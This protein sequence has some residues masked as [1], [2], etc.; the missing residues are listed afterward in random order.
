MKV[1]YI[2]ETIGGG[3]RRHL[4]LLLENLNDKYELVVIHGP[5]FDN[6]FKENI[7]KYKQKGIKLYCLP[8]FQREIN[9]KQDIR[10][11]KSVLNILKKEKPDIVHCHSSK[12]GVIGR[13]AAKVQHVP[14]I[15]YTPHGYSFQAQEFSKNKKKLFSYIEKMASKFLTTLTFNVSNGEREEAL[16][17]NVDNID[18]FSVI[19]NGLP[20]IVPKKLNL[21][22]FLGIPMDSIIVGN[23]A[24]VTLQK[25]P[26]YF[27]DIALKVIS[28][29]KKYHFVWI[30]EGLDDDI[31]KYNNLSENIHF[32]GFNKDADSLMKDF[33]IFLS[34]SYYEGMPYSLIEALRVGV[35]IIAT[36]V[37][38][39]N[40]IVID[41]ITGYLLTSN[42]NIVELINKA[43]KLDPDKIQMQF[44]KEYSLDTMI[45]KIEY[46]YDKKYKK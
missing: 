46:F 1:V 32:I 25:N 44:Q 29:N 45:K 33:D 28:K 34:T 10:T 23:C 5:R 12:A 31:K 8:T 39:N 16:L 14:K 15:F 19:Y 26:D 4:D 27:I 7:K 43:M 20:N 6:V 40:E 38:G 3:V 24:R 22:D 21:R 37:V 11:Y 13:I 41:G 17:R 30:G 42:S 9:L 35:P 2:A 18:K 36:D